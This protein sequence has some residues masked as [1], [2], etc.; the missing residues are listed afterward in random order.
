MYTDG[1]FARILSNIQP[2]LVEDDPT[3][4]LE[5]SAQD[6]VEITPKSLVKV[7]PSKVTRSNVFKSAEAHPILLDLLLL[8]K[9]GTDWLRWEVD[10]MSRRVREDFGTA[11][12]A[13]LNIEK[14]QACRVLHLVDDFWS[15]WEVFLPCCMAFNG[16]FADFAQMQVPDVAYCMVAVDVASRIRDDI[17]WSNEVKKYLEVVHVHSHQLCP[18]PPLD[19]VSMEGYEFPTEV[20]CSEIRRRWADV[21][22]QNRAPTGV[23]VADEQLRRMLG[24]WRYLESI[25]ARLREQL[26]ILQY[27]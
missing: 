8:Q 7:P 26:P 16:T 9:Y 13:D 25:R 19:F 18:I 4:V 23:S 20:S 6:T 17:E 24:S 3:T 12:V 21:R 14:L 11:T 15:R 2:I 27:G 10:T 22:I 1:I 5:T